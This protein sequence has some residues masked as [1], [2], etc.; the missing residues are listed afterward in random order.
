MSADSV[1][2]PFLK[3]KNPSITDA[4]G[5]VYLVS[6][7]LTGM[8][9]RYDA[10]D[11]LNEP[12]M[13]ELAGKRWMPFCPE[14]AGGLP[15]PR[16]AARI[17]GGDGHDVIAGR[18]RVLTRETGADVTGAFIMGA[19]AA[20]AVASKFRAAA[21]YFKGGSPSCGLNPRMCADGIPRVRGVAAAMLI[22]N[23]FRVI[24]ID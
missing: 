19:E 20:L 16:P 8:L 7:C 24:E 2:Q 9:T 4:E 1:H 15:T 21:V 6:A 14:E 18:A 3:T 12:L 11:A 10:T 13:R 5:Q 23:G 17:V 22:E